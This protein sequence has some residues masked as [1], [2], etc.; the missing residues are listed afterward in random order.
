MNLDRRNPALEAAS[1]R[2]EAKE[3]GLIKT[4]RG[5]LG[6]AVGLAAGLLFSPHSQPE[7][8]QRGS[9][10]VNPGGDPQVHTQIQGVLACTFDANGEPVCIPLLPEMLD[11]LEMGCEPLKYEIPPECFPGTLQQFTQP[12]VE[13]KPGVSL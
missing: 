3:E 11:E 10:G 5:K 2:L 9:E 8:T 4:H 6:L 7:V 12:Q 13:E 1:K